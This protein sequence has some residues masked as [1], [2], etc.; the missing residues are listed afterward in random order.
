MLAGGIVT[1]LEYRYTSL[2]MKSRRPLDY[3]DI[4]V[5]PMIDE[6]LVVL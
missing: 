1:P 4:N 2:E 3:V 5:L 6:A